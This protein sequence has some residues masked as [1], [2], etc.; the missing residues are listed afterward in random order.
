MK[1]IISDWN[2][3]AVGSWNTAIINPDWLT[4]KK[5]ISGQIEIEFIIENLRPRFRI[6]LDRSI[7]IPRPDRIIVGV[8]DKHNDNLQQAEGVLSRLLKD[9]PVTPIAAV[10][11]NIS[12]N[13]LEPST[14][15]LDMFETKDINRFT[16]KGIQINTTSLVRSFQYDSDFVCNFTSAIQGDGS[17]VFKANYHSPVQDATAAALRVGN[18]FIECRDHFRELLSTLYNVQED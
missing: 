13:E 5:I 1:P 7:I 9:L 15:V 8:R 10:G 11:V 17:V 18:K 12:Y 16:E 4:E 6:L 14:E 2:M 3:V